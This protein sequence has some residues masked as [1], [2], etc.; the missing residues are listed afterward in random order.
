MG[1]TQNNHKSSQFIKIISFG[2]SRKYTDNYTY[3]V[4]SGVLASDLKYLKV[5][6]IIDWIS[7]DT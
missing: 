6:K 1:L 2:F 3:A 4:I 5:A 7:I